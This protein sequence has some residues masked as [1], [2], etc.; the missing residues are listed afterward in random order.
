M[1]F[2]LFSF[3]AGVATGCGQTSQ[4]TKPPEDSAAGYRQR[5]ANESAASDKD[6]NAASAAN[7]A[8]NPPNLSASGG[9]N[10][11]G[12]Y[13][14][15]NVYNARNQRL[16]RA[17][18]LSEHA[19]QHEAMASRLE[20]FVEAECKQL[21]PATRAACPLLGPVSK[22]VDL[23]D[24]V[25]V[26]FA[27][28][29]RVDAVLAHMQCHLAFARAR[30]FEESAAACPLYVR[31]IEIR[32]GSDP[33]TIDILGSDAKVAREVQARTREEAVLVRAASN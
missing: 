30:G 27:P 3:L 18:E 32:A 6:L 28:G 26:E 11:Q 7:P 24:G 19:H 22:L 4:S 8:P 14:D 2:A 15:L 16:A 5:A 9:N 31:G 13:Y 33:R 12:Y 10:P 1:V 29:T 20:G 23:P 21:P 25:H 17:R